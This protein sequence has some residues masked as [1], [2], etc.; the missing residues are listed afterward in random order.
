LLQRSSLDLLIF[1]VKGGLHADFLIIS[2][3][4]KWNQWNEE[5]LCKAAALQLEIDKSGTHFGCTENESKVLNR[6]DFFCAI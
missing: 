3:Y 1:R 4:E 5:N 2:P 6:L